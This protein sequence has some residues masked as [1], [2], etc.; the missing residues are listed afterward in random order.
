AADWYLL[1]SNG[2]LYPL[3]SSLLT[4]ASWVFA[5]VPG[6][7][8]LGEDYENDV[9]WYDLA[10]TPSVALAGP[11]YVT[12]SLTAVGTP[13]KALVVLTG[14]ESHYDAPESK[15]WLEGAI[16]SFGESTWT[17]N[18]REDKRYYDNGSCL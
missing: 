8:F 7:G 17:A 15:T 9:R 1:D 4:S 2:G 3:I 12:Q 18:F 6:N 14:G 13:G 11:G 10:G 5:A 16:M